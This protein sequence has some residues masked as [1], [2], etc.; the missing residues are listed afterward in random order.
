MLRLGLCCL[1]VDHPIKFRTAT[2]RYVSGL[3]AE[4][5]RAY[6]TG[7]AEN[8]AA[9]LAESVRT[10][11]ALGIGAFRINSQILPL[12]THPV[13]GYTIDALNDGPLL[14][15]AFAA[16]AP[17]ARELNVR[18]SFHPDQFVVLNSERESVRTASIEEFEFQC[19]VA[20]LV[21][22]D[23]VTLHVGGAAGGTDAALERLERTI[24]LLSPT[25]RARL[26]LENDDRLFAPRDLL[27]LCARTGV[28]LVYDSHH[29]RCNPDDLS[30]AD[31]SHLAAATWSARDTGTL[32]PLACEPWFHVSSPRDGWD[33]KNARP[34]ADYID[35]ADVPEAWLSMDLT[36]DVEAKAKERAVLRLARD[37]SERVPAPSSD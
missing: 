25:A 12:A 21:G 13:T 28:P 4:A 10:C 33:A 30:T 1:F 15:D 18:L 35:V 16:V 8:N 6:L 36:V 22:A 29:H 31:A 17:L 14:R 27:P 3:D 9:A 2:H 11:R 7:I 34:H 37:L 23:T 32:G 26:A 19:G 20:A 5:G 24:D